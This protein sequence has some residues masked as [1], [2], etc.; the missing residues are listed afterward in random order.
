MGT[1]LDQRSILNVDLS[2]TP[3]DPISGGLVTEDSFK[4]VFPELN[5]SGTLGIVI[6][7]FELGALF[8]AL[9]C[10]DLGDRL[11]RRLTV[12]LGMVFMLIG[13]I[14]QTSAW[15]TAQLTVGRV[16]SGSGLG[17]Q[18]ATVPSWQAECA[19]GKSRGRWVMIEGGLRKCLAN[20]LPTRR[21]SH[22][23]LRC[24]VHQKPPVSPSV[25][26][27][28]QILFFRTGCI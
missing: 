19:K 22:H 20:A 3:N 13:G 23:K 14:L 18:V 15:S 24:F 4:T 8:G 17:L 25:S 28:F 21:H 5:N 11:G 2:L 10:L 27:P 6:A 16:I 26:D 9:A 12:Q 1:Y 7:S